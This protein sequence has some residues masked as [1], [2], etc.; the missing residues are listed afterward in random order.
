MN[1]DSTWPF[2]GAFAPLAAGLRAPAFATGGQPPSPT[3]VLDDVTLIDGTGAAAVPGARLA[4]A[5]GRIQRVGRIGEVPVP[6]GADLV[7]LGGRTIMPGLVDAHFHIE[8]ASGS[9]SGSWPTASR[10]FAILAPGSR[11]STP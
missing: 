8:D 10:P 2:P 4:I 11:S 5:G 7:A 1:A 9:R 3:I 6:A